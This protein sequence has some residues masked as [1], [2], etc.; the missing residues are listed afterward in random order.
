MRCPKCGFISFDNVE[1]C[2]KCK[3]D[4]SE[5]SA[6]FQ[7]TTFNVATPV[8]LKFSAQDEDDDSAADGVEDIDSVQE[9]ADPDLEI[10]VEDGEEGEI[11]FSME[12][13]GKDDSAEADA[14]IAQEF[15][16]AETAEEP[17]PIADSEATLDLGM[18]EDGSEEDTFSFDDGDHADSAG[19]A[20]LEI[21]EELSDISDLS[22]PGSSGDDEML[23]FDDELPETST[24][25][26]G[27]GGQ[28]A[29]EPEE[30]LDFGS[31]DMNFSFDD[32][33]PEDVG[34]SVHDDEAAA[35]KKAP[36]RGKAGMDDDL[37]LDLDLGGLSI[38]DER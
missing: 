22:P 19:G 3:K 29:G 8:Y 38:H 35:P 23:S 15:G 36:A 18:F 24:A 5:V 14:A 34:I 21:P 33:E 10:L 6:A 26:A 37:D 30:E 9:F 25:P 4:I 31:L 17:E 20:G 2:L 27:Q 1:T 12:G 32:D 28:V 16:A 11:N 7:G 13:Y